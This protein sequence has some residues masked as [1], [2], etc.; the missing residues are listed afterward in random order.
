MAF[1]FKFSVIIAH[2]N[3][4]FAL[5]QIQSMQKHKIELNIYTNFSF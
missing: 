5:S 1:S 2:R 4:E 3:D